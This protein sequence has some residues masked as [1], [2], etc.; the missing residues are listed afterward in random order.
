MYD[1]PVVHHSYEESKFKLNQYIYSI[2]NNIYITDEEG[3]N[4]DINK[5]KNKWI[6]Y[7]LSVTEDR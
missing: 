5:Y 2:S 1:I 3:K 6:N 4:I 7:I